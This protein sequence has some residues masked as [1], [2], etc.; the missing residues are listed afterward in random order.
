MTDSGALTAHPTPD[1][2]VAFSMPSVSLGMTG[3]TDIAQVLIL[4]HASIETSFEMQAGSLAPSYAMQTAASTVSSPSGTNQVAPTLNPS[5]AINVTAYGAVGDGKADDAK[6]IQAAE[7]AAHAE[8]KALYFPPR[9]YKVNETI[10]I[11]QGDTLLGAGSNTILSAGGSNATVLYAA[12]GGQATRNIGISDLTLEGNQ[13]L[14]DP[15]NSGSVVIAYRVKGLQFSDCTI[16]NAPRIGVLLSDVNDSG[17]TNCSFQKIG[18]TSRDNSTRED[19]A[20]AQ[21]VAFSSDPGVASTGN[22][23]DGCT[24]SEIGLDAIS[25]TGQNDFTVYNNTLQYLNIESASFW[26][27]KNAGSAGIYMNGNNGVAIVGNQISGASGN[28]LDFVNSSHVEIRENS[29]V[30]NGSSGINMAADSNVDIIHNKLNNNNQLNNIFFSQAGITISDNM[31]AT[32]GPTTKYVDIN[33]NTITDTQN[34]KTQNWAIQANVEA[35]PSNVMIYSN[36]T[37]SGNISPGGVGS[38]GIAQAW[39]QRG[40]TQLQTTQT[41]SGSTVWDPSVISGQPFTASPS[42]FSAAAASQ[43]ITSSSTIS[44]TGDPMTTVSVSESDSVLATT[45]ISANGLWSLTPSLSAGFHRLAVVEG[46]VFGTIDSTTI[47]FAVDSAPPLLKVT[48]STTLDGGSGTNTVPQEFLSGIAT[49]GSTLAF[50]DND[51]SFGSS[52]VDSSGQWQFALP[53]LSDAANISVT[54]T[55]IAGNMATQSVMVRPDNFAL[56]STNTGNLLIH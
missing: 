27:D 25:A 35:N 14:P 15:G 23:I 11:E 54:E 3:T 10:N 37:L 34:T 49:P 52:I 6:A 48:A 40:S 4:P 13:T 28:G 53:A 30:T 5:E 7:Q 56:F 2:P 29:F 45:T 55:D 26:S 8:N 39:V 18:Y 38:S 9:T 43:G 44:G 22:F 17:F 47:S 41:T 32:I 16:E 20:F 12:P 21:G 19:D 51:N 36:N 42:Y 31:W 46:D 33:G 50:I 1:R 24:L